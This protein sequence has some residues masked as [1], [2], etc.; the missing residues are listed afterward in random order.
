MFPDCLIPPVLLPSSPTSTF[1]DVLKAETM[2]P[3][4]TLGR[5][6]NAA[7]S[8]GYASSSSSKPLIYP[9]GATKV[10]HLSTPFQELVVA[11]HS[12]CL[13]GRDDEDHDPNANQDGATTPDPHSGA[14]N[15]RGLKPPANKV[16]LKKLGDQLPQ[17]EDENEEDEEERLKEDESANGR[18][19]KTC[20]CGHDVSEHGRI[21]EEGNEER[22]RRIKVAI[23]LDELL[24]VSHT[25]RWERDS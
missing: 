19:W 1:F 5:S 4:P 22:R 21:A 8:L 20:A 9:T 18:D 2:A 17:D 6:T 16:V 25:V 3:A 7:R 24:M 12:I 13:A 15:C 11:R 23:R 10:E 14:C